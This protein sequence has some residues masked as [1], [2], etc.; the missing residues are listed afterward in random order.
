MNAAPAGIIMREE[1][2]PPRFHRNMKSFPPDRSA[3][4][5]IAHPSAAG[6]AGRMRQR[7]IPLRLL[8]AGAA[9]RSAPALY[10]LFPFFIF[11]F[12]FLKNV[13]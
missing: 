1:T 12:L 5:M 10:F 4:V 3:V 7:K 2:N 9:G 11:I 13:L 8:A 6:R